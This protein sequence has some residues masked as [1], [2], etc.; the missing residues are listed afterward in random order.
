MANDANAPVRQLDVPPELTEIDLHITRFA[1]DG[2][3]EWYPVL[4]RPLSERDL[5]R[6]IYRAMWL[7]HLGSEGSREAERE[8]LSTMLGYYAMPEPA[9]LATW[10]TELSTH[11][12]QLAELAQKGVS[13]TEQLIKNLTSGHGARQAQQQV[14]TL[15]ALDEEMRLFSELHNA[16]KPLILIAKF[17]REN[18]EGADP[19]VL[20]QTTLQIYHDCY[21]RAQMM[22]T[23]LNLLF[24]LFS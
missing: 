21:T 24:S 8:S 18:L 2:C 9:Q 6:I 12:D 7:D 17:E 4:R 5:L 13:E 23:K 3:L 1:P 20:A 16:C 15:M 10:K 22:R 19:V 14:Q 11:F